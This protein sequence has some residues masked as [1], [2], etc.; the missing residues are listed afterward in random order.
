MTLP[1][2]IL[3]ALSL[4]SLPAGAGSVPDSLEQTLLN[5]KQALHLELRFVSENPNANYL[6]IDLPSRNVYLKAG[7]HVLRVCAIQHYRLAGAF[8]L[9]PSQLRMIDRLYPHSVE[10]GNSGLRL[11]GRRLPIDFSGRLIEG[12]R[13]RSRL[14]FSPALLI[15]P[16]ELPLP[17]GAIGIALVS[18]DIKA[19]DSALGPGSAAILVPSVHFTP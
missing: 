1:A 5:R 8:R 18:S 12:P 3:I 17:A 9:S 15:Q 10:P 19:L 6:V 14:Y 13:G 11:R 16:H 2:A 7:A 4:S